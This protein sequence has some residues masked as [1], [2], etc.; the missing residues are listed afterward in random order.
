MCRDIDKSRAHQPF[1]WRYVIGCLTSQDRAGMRIDCRMTN[2]A[3]AD[4]IN[5]S[6]TLYRAQQL[7][8]SMLGAANT[9]F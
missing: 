9:Q 2:T 8:D 7:C 1:E 5:Y 4:A 6:C 3:T